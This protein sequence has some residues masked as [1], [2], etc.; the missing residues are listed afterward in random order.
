[1][2]HLS[3]AEK[4]TSTNNLSNIK[5]EEPFDYEDHQKRKPKQNDGCFDSKQ[6]QR[7]TSGYSQS[8]KQKYEDKTDVHSFKHAKTNNWKVQREPRSQNYRNI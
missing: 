8:R 7:G 5:T 2:S 6:S 1:M 4:F 3:K